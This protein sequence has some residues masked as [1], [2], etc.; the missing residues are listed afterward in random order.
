MTWKLGLFQY[1]V[2]H[3][4]RYIWFRPKRRFGS[5]LPSRLLVIGCHPTDRFYEY[6]LSYDVTIGIE[7]GIF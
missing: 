6:L 5:R 7:S 1:Y 4:L 3:Y 2:G